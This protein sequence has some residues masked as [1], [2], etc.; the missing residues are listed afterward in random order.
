ML[1]Q[2]ALAASVYGKSGVVPV[3]IG[4]ALI[5]LTLCWL[6]MLADCLATPMPWRE[7][8]KWLCVV[9]FLYVVGAAIYYRRHGPG[10][11]GPHGMARG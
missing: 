4:M 10:W 6:W 7:K 1:I 5:P 2:N 3:L 8:I 11:K 9:F